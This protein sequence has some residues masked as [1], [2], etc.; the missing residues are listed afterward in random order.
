MKAFPK[1]ERGE[2][3]ISF[4]TNILSELVYKQ[5]HQMFRS[6]TRLA[7]R[8]PPSNSPDL[9]LSTDSISSAI[10]CFMGHT[11]ILPIHHMR[12]SIVQHNSYRDTYSPIIN[13]GYHI[14]SYMITDVTTRRYTPLFLF[15]LYF[16]RR[17]IFSTINRDPSVVSSAIPGIHRNTL[18]VYRPL[19]IFRF[20]YNGTKCAVQISCEAE[21]L[22]WSKTIQIIFRNN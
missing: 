22:Q 20:A 13:V 3:S 18:F 17:P 15:L 9:L 4:D 5:I 6:A 7:H 11:P 14:T 8:K 10:R 21:N 16:S 2:K 1:S 19:K 12:P